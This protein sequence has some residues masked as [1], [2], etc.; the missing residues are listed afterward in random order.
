MGISDWIW[1]AVGAV[2]LA[3]AARLWQLGLVRGYPFLTSYLV[4]SAVHSIVS[5]ATYNAWGQN[6]AAYGWLWTVTQPVLW[7][8]LFCVVIEAYNHMLKGYEGLQRLGQWG[9]N[10][11]L[12]TVALIVLVMVVLDP[13]VAGA[14]SPWGIFWIRQERSVYIALTTICL[15]LVSV[16]AYYGLVV[17]RNVATVFAVFGFF[18]LSHAGLAVFR[19]HLGAEFRM[20]RYTVAPILYIL[21]V[22]A[23]A[24]A[25]TRIGEERPSDETAA[26]WGDAAG[27]TGHLTRQLESVNQ[28]LLRVL[29]S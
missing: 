19:D 6:S 17:S 2:E 12:G 9:S 25:F 15:V 3:W 13:P 18:F 16:G 11:A 14:N 5:F 28:L 20:I 26:A 7:V 27:T 10:I 4:F 29:R 1:A 23:G 22:I 21:W 24:F 8:F